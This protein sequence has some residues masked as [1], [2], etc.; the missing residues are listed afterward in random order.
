MEQSECMILF[1]EDDKVDRMAFERFARRE[2]FPYQ[3]MLA[4]SIEETRQL[5]RTRHFDAAVVDY[6]LGDGTAFDLFDS[7]KGTP[8]V[9]VTGSEDAEIADLAAEPAQHRHQHE[10]IGIEEL[11]RSA[12]VSR[13]NQLVAGR[14]NRN[15]DAP[16][17]IDLRQSEG[18]D[19]RELTHAGPLA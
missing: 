5:V 3:Y 2:H 8:I 12:H 7:A 4:G 18:G 11:R 13:R 19:E 17:Y 1:V 10:A 14:E 9:V 15:A 6:L 16:P